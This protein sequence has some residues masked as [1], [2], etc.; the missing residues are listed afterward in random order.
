MAKKVKVNF[1]YPTYRFRPNEQ[2]PVVDHVR[3]AVDDT[4][5][6]HRDIS[7]ASHVSRTTLRNWFDGATRCP[8][9]ATV[10]AVMGALGYRQKWTRMQKTAEKT[11][12]R[13]TGVMREDR[14]AI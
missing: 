1:I 4:G 12:S 14:Y 6:S 2:D 9:H 5:M 7:I 8:R 13:K 3:T 10:C 11:A